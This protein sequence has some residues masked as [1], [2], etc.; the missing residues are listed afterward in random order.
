LFSEVV[1]FFSFVKIDVEEKDAQGIAML[2]INNA[3]FSIEFIFDF[4]QKI[5]FERQMRLQTL[6][7][8]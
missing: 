1:Q 4:C 3:D 5:F 8:G 2:K 6:T 7:E